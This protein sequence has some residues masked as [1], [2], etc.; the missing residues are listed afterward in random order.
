MP[1][2]ARWISRTVA[3]LVV[4]GVMLGLLPP[5]IGGSPP[6]V[7]RSLRLSLPELVPHH[8]AAG[9]TASGV[10]MR[11]GAWTARAEAC[12]PI[13]FTMAGITWRQQ[14]SDPV[15]ARVAWGAQGSF[16]PPARLVADRE[17][18]PDQ[19]SP[20][21][22]GIV[23][24][25]LQWT[26]PSD[27]L[28]FR[29]R[30]DRDHRYED[31][32]AVFIN[33]SGTAADPS[34]L[35]MLGSALARMWGLVAP[36]PAAAMPGR[37][38]II[39]RKGWGANESWRS[40]YCDGEPDYAPKLKMA[41]VHHTA[42][43]NTYSKEEAD[44]VVRGVYSYHVNSLHYCD[45]A[46]NFLIDRFGRIYEGRYG[47]MAKPVIGGHAMGFNTGS[48]GVAAMGDFSTVVPPRPVRMAYKRLLAWRLDIAHQKPTGFTVMTS[49]GGSNQKFN[50][51]QKVRL[52]VISGHRDT[53]YTVCPGGELYGRLGMIRQGAAARGGPK[54]WKP[55]QTKHEMEPGQKV[56]WTAELSKKL[57]WTIRV[58]TAEGVQ[59]RTFTGTA[60]RIDR[61]WQGKTKQGVPVLPG[62]YNVWMEAQASATAV[63]RPAQFTLRIT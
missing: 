26:G 50:K 36:E 18:G 49:A 13:R 40:K 33:T 21:D 60:A 31:L 62:T 9:R 45:I 56:R 2:P 37:P 3:S 20:D 29:L 57:H 15:E 24:T 27:C 44:D 63:A 55:R 14:G 35:A 47:G 25:P 48:T 54:I 8:A 52:R 51:G 38:A 11:E 22:S 10:Q 12:S 30:L 16:G 43:S 6:T 19:G 4:A 1:A 34:P 17:E 5:A 7:M 39:Q 41:Y 32:R 61:A 28:R 23:G 42:G 53:G 46:Y 58:L 59:V